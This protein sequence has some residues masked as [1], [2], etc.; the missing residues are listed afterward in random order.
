VINDYERAEKAIFHGMEVVEHEVQKA[1]ENEVYSIFEEMN[2]DRRKEV[3]EHVKKAV[4]NGASKAKSTAQREYKS[5]PFLPKHAEEEDRHDHR[6]LHAMEAAE[7]AVLNAV[8]E[9]VDTLFHDS[10]HP[11]QAEPQTTKEAKKSAKKGFEKA[12]KRV[13]DTH[14]ERKR[15]IHEMDDKAIDE[16]IKMTN[17]MYGMGF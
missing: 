13:E 9:E 10:E 2:H 6:I 14:K 16:Y 5:M 8:K 3:T 4:T 11:L 17:S 12:A 1:V 15:W 7:R